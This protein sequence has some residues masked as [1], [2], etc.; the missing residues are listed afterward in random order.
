MTDKTIENRK[1]AEI[2]KKLRK[3]YNLSQEQVAE[4]LGIS[5]NTYLAIE[6]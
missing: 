5:R 6:G 3:D 4:F 1:T 2:V